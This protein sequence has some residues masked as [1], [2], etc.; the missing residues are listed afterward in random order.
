MNQTPK[1]HQPLAGLNTSNFEFSN[2]KIAVDAYQEKDYKKSFYTLMD[3]INPE[4]RKKFGNAEQT[5]FEVPHGSIVV[6]IKL[7]DDQIEVHA[8]FLQ[9]PETNVIPIL[10]KVAELNFSPLN[11]AAIRLKDQFLE[12]Y[13][14][15][16]LNTCEPY[17]MYYLLKEI[18]MTGDTYDDYFTVKHHAKRIQDPK[19]TP[20]STIQAEQAWTQTC[21]YIDEAMEYVSYFDGKR[22]YQYSS[23]ILALALLKI[24]HYAS[25]QGIIKNEL[26]DAVDYLYTHN[27]LQDK[28]K[29]SKKALMK[30]KER[31]KE[32]FI[33]DL[34]RAETF[35]AFKTACSLVDRQKVWE[36]RLQ[37]ATEELNSNNYMG[38]VFNLMNSFYDSSFYNT[39]PADLDN[40]INNLLE[41]ASGKDWKEA[42][43]ILVIGMKSIVSGNIQA[44][45]K[46]VAAPVAAS[47]GGF[48][49][50]LFGN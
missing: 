5:Y 41:N 28:I 6:H 13:F 50:K 43:E 46:P 24:E 18:C 30:I 22:W 17:K 37:Q 47:K 3:Y 36:P 8:P 29:S 39:I 12:F 26:E 16:K 44:V 4:L 25:P 19:V 7:V 2:W 35:V 33:A 15:C 45:Q 27:T 21:S 40:F 31:G 14:Q 11:L 42:A 32:A 10:R 9:L 20:Y 23:E 48:F 38:V 1:F 34:Y 49:S